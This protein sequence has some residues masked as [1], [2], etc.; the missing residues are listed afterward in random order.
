MQAWAYE[1]IQDFLVSLGFSIDLEQG[2]FT[3]WITGWQYI[4]IPFSELAGHTVATFREK[5]LKRG[6]LLTEEPPSS[7]EQQAFV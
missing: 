5:A 4:H 1:S 6:W 3:K 7:P 2:Q